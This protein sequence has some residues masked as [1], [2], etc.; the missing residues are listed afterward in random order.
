[1]AGIDQ[2]LFAGLNHL[3]RNEAWARERLRPFSGAQILIVAGPFKLNLLIDEQGLL[4]KGAADQ[5]VD[6]TLTLPA[7]A[8]LRF[9]LDRNSLFS[10]VKL[11]G[12]ADVAES[13]AFVFRNL[14]WDVEGDL[15]GVV[16][17]IPARRIS[18]LGARL[19]G[20]L[21]DSARKLGVNVV[22]YATEDS[23][24]L[25][26]GRD[27]DSLGRAVDTL[28]DDLARLEQRIKRL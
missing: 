12:A 8:P 14:R 18:L 4:T 1:M 11:A 28:R 10:S 2:L 19:A 20:E 17:D 9:L 24:L 7:D 6:V 27:I 16:G 5:P 25:A 26:P 3:L 23:A 13:L 22:E 15:A 21:Q